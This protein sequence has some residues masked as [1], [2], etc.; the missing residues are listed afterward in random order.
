MLRDV[1]GL[2]A[3]VLRDPRTG[4]PIV[5]PTSSA[6]TAA[7]VAGWRGSGAQAAGTVVAGSPSAAA[8]SCGT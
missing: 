4:L 2:D 7:A 3:D 8:A 5:V 1:F 6:A